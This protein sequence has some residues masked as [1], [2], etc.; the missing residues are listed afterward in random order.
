MSSV[1]QTVVLIQD[2]NIIWH[3]IFHVEEKSQCIYIPSLFLNWVAT[4]MIAHCCQ[5]D[6]TSGKKFFMVTCKFHLFLS[7]CDFKRKEGKDWQLPT[8]Y[9]TDLWTWS[10][11]PSFALYQSIDFKSIFTSQ[12]FVRIISIIIINLLESFKLKM[13]LNAKY[14]Y[15]SDVILFCSLSSLTLFT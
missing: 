4:Y 5:P 14:C 2:C 7:L 11:I 13:L 15:Y 3:N 10:L 1:P 12:W 9:G 8:R 6:A